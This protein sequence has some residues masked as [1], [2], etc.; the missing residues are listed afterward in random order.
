MVDVL[1]IPSLLAKWVMHRPPFPHIV[2]SLPSELKY[3]MRK[4]PSE[5]LL[6]SIR[7]SAPIPKC[8]SQSF[9]IS[10]VETG[11]WLSLSS[12]IIKSF[13]APWYFENVSCMVRLRVVCYELSVGSLIFSV[14]QLISTNLINLLILAPKKSSSLQRLSHSSFGYIAFKNSHWDNDSSNDEWL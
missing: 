10:S 4:S 3:R 8:L 11:N 7:P 14:F 5:E 6:R 2:D 12:M 13:P 1:I 9:R